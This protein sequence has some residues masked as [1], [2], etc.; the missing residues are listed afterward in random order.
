MNI[1][2]H[3]PQS[4]LLRHLLLRFLYPPLQNQSGIPIRIDVGSNTSKVNPRRSVRAK[5]DTKDLIGRDWKNR[6][7]IPKD[8]KSPTWMF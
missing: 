6:I 4:L 8:R 2:I 5:T 1:R 3:R 7:H